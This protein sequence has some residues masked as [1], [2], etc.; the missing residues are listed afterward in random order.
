MGIEMVTKHILVMFLLPVAFYNIMYNNLKSTIFISFLFVFL[1]GMAFVSIF[2]NHFQYENVGNDR[3]GSRPDNHTHYPDNIDQ[4][5]NSDF[6][7]YG[8]GELPKSC[9]YKDAETCD[10]DRPDTFYPRGC[11]KQLKRNY[12]PVY[13]LNIILQVL[14]F[15][16]MVILSFLM[17]KGANSQDQ[18]LV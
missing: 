17:I 11:C 7:V 4:I 5:Q 8:L 3:R 18:M 15:P 9:C 10:K 2:Y 1:S 13:V 6:D 16:T 14:T 12:Y